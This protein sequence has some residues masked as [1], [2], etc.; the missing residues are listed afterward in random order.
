MRVTARGGACA[1]ARGRRQLHLAAKRPGPRPVDRA[2]DDDPVQPRPEGP[3]AVEAVERAYGGQEGFLGDVLCSC[4]VVADEVGGAVGPR[5]VRAE[6]RLEVRGRP[7]LSAR[8]PRRARRGRLPSRTD[9]TSVL[10]QEVH[11]RQYGRPP[12]PGPTSV[13]L[14]VH[15][16][17]A[18]AWMSPRLREPVSPVRISSAC[19]VLRDD[20]E[21]ISGR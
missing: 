13:D 18:S 6:Q 14:P 15:D 4:G 16:D 9:Y 5:P 17:L 19:L 3:A 12:A 7:G 8:A 1:A 11:R 20:R 10:R 2:V 21:P